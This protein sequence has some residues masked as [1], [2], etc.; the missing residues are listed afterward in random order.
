M[1]L[2]YGDGPGGVF[3]NLAHAFHRDVLSEPVGTIPAI[4]FSEFQLVFLATVCAISVGGSC[5]RGRILP[6]VPFIF[7][8]ATFIYCPLAHM[9]WGGGFL[10]ELGVLDF[11]GAHLYTFAAA[12]LLQRSACTCHIQ[13]PG[14]E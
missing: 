12:R 13:S 8:W 5:E 11:A 14:L 9:V 3:G 7:L 6:L 4:L 10:A 2:A 1:G